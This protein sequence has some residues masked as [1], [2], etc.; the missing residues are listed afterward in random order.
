MTPPLAQQLNS[1]GIGPECQWKTIAH[2]FGRNERNS[3]YVCCFHFARR[4]VN[5]QRRE[6]R[7]TYKD[8]PGYISIQNGFNFN[9]YYYYYKLLVVW[10]L[11]YI[12]ID[13]DTFLHIVSLSVKCKKGEEKGVCWSG[14]V[15]FLHVY[16]CSLHNVKSILLTAITA[17]KQPT[18]VL[19]L[20]RILYNTTKGEI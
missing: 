7:Q 3:F 4:Y 13:K 16:T 11:L 18:L 12:F 20:R 10:Q 8:C 19:Y 1:N 9:N 15:T 2:W 17:I 6:N 14:P 5:R